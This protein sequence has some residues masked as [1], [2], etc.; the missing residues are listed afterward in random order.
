MHKNYLEFVLIAAFNN[1]LSYYTDPL[2]K[3]KFIS[4]TMFILF[5]HSKDK[6]FF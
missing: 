5:L 2:K 1:V 3:C 6:C 4:Q